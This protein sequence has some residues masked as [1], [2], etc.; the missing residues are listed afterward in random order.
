MLAVLLVPGFVWIGAARAGGPG[1]LTVHFFDVG[2]GD[3]ALVQSPGGAN[4]LIDGGPETQDVAVKLASLGVHRLDVVVATHPHK[5]HVAGLPAVLARFPVGMVLDPGCFGDS[6]FYADFLRAVRDE[7][8]PVRHP[9]PGE[10]VRVGD[11][12]LETLG[13]DRCYHGTN[14]DPNNDS[15]VLRVAQGDAAVLFPGDAEEPAQERVLDTQPAELAAD[16]LK[17]PHH[18]GDTSLPEFL[19]AIRATVAIVSVGQPNPYGHPSPNV[20]AELGADGMKVYRTDQVGD[21]VVTFDRRGI[22][23]ASDR[24]A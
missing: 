11:L 2:Q 14:S 24:A 23:V 4:V 12:R 13:P 8:I 10:V 15:L 7:G 22:V 17:V 16:V 19:L 18:G 3:G 20:I 9:G 1:A 21:V 5:D 6:P